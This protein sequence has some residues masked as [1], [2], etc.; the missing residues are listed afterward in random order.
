MDGF[1]IPMDAAF[2]N[3]SKPHSSSA[4]FHLAQQSKR[5][6]MSCSSH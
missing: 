5:K 6:D 3:S 4:D 2:V 1:S